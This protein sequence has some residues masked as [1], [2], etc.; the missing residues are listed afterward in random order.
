[1]LTVNNYD[2]NM[3]DFFMLMLVF[4]VS[5]VQFLNTSWESGYVNRYICILSMKNDT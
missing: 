5:A 2:D 1:M 4:T 3:I